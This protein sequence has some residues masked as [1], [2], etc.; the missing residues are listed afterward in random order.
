MTKSKLK[1]F[2]D[3][4][5]TWPGGFDG[6]A[7]K[8]A[9]EVFG[10]MFIQLDKEEEMEEMVGQKHV[11][12]PPFG[13]PE[14]SM[15]EVFGFYDH[16]MLFTSI[17]PFAY[18]DVYNPAEAPNRR[19]KRLIEIENNRERKKERQEFIAYVRKMVEMLRSKDPRFIKFTA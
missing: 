18:A 19:V 5:K 15:E 14:A 10:P 8:N 9:Y 2:M 1:P 16:W 13:G 17:K 7:E 3:A 4:K 6:D 11:A 12:A